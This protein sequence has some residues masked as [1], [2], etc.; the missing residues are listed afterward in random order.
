MHKNEPQEQDEDEDKSK[1][2]M[3]KIVAIIL[4]SY[5][6]IVCLILICVFIIALIGLIIYP[7][8]KAIELLKQYT[9]KLLNYFDSKYKKLMILLPFIIAIL[10]KIIIA[11]RSYTPS[12]N[13]EDEDEKT[14]NND[15]Y[16]SSLGMSVLLSLI[17]FAFSLFYAIGQNKNEITK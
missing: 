3:E 11:I 13:D 1:E 12:A 5:L 9:A 16:M 2:V 14:D 8:E 4:L 6:F 7:K 15:T 10:L 17:L